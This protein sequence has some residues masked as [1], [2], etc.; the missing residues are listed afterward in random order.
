MVTIQ[1]KKAFMYDEG[2]LYK[3]KDGD[4]D[5]EKRLDLTMRNSYSR[6]T[7]DSKIRLDI[8]KWLNIIKRL[9]TL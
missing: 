6:L 3:R 5:T 4:I 9:N 8:S 2:D 7:A 1:D